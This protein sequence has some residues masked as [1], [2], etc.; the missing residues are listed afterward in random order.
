[1]GLKYMLALLL[2][3]TFVL[4]FTRVVYN[5][6]LGLVLTVA[7]IAASVYRG[8]TDSMLLIIIDAFSLTVGFYFANQMVHRKKQ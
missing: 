3:G 5:H 4:F 6:Y 2:P 1:M 8:Y 7:L